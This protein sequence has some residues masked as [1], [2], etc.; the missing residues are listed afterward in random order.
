MIIRLCY[1]RRVQT[2]LKL[3]ACVLSAIFYFG[4]L[5]RESM[6]AFEQN[7]DKAEAAAVAVGL[8]QS[9]SKGEIK[10]VPSLS[11][12]LQ[13]SVVGERSDP[14]R[15]MSSAT[16][17][18]AS[19]SWAYSSTLNPVYEYSEEIHSATENDLKQR[20]Q[21]LHQ[22]CEKYNLYSF[23]P[24][25]P[26]EFFI[27][28]GHNL[29]WCNV[30]KAA[31]STWMY[32]FNILGGYDPKYLQKIET[33]PIELARQRFPRPYLQD[34]L[35]S[36]PSSLSFLF[37]RDPFERI[38]S[39]YR[40]KLEGGKNTYYKWLANRIIKG[41]RKHSA[42]PG[43]PKGPTFDEFV[44]YLIDQHGNQ[45]AFN[46]HWAPIYNFC[47][48][49]SIN[50]TI[51]GK[52]ETFNRDSEYIIRQAG[53]ESLLLGKLPK[54]ALKR[55]GN[56]S[57]GMKTFTSLEKYFSQI[58]RST[59]DQLIDIYKLDFELFDY[60]YTKYYGYVMPDDIQSENDISATLGPI[61]KH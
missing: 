15:Q 51:I 54:S 59:L 57:K 46:E 23:Y 34:L 50:F 39:G 33:P 18:A 35:D 9:P 37:A 55:I 21:H 30:F 2:S 61:I 6:N 13:K 29:V 53:L 8:I 14:Q 36:L 20:R 52:V 49:C 25:M 42:T 58:K 44:Q 24:P 40:N 45:K 26:K 3:I 38:V 4:F 60:D 31:S 5:F 7:K 27:S 12:R 16:S 17:S 47:T 19:S 56:L 43:R 22:I 32:Y 48:P 1:G 41:F 28:P 10:N 11:K